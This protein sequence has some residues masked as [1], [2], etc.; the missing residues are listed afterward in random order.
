M[1]HIIR[2]LIIALALMAGIAPAV[3]QS[4][5]PVPPLPDTERRT[6]YTISNSTCSCA[7]GFALYGDGSDYANWIEVWVNG[8]QISQSGNWTISSPS[9]GSLSIA[10]RPITDAVLTFT[11][12]QTG[13]VQIVGARRP[14]RVSQYAE[15]RGVPA[16]NLNQDIS[17]IVATQRETWDKL[18]DVTGRAVLAPPG[19]TLAVL[20]A[21]SSRANSGA[22]FD[23][24]GNLVSCVSIPSTT[25]TAGNGIAITGTNPKTITNNIQA[26]GPITIT[27]TNPLIIGCPTCNTSPASATS[28]IF[29]AS[30]ATAATLDLSSYSVVKTGGYAT[31][32]DGG[33]AT[34]TKVVGAPFKDTYITAGS[35][36]GVGSGYTNGTYLGVRMT[37]GVGQGCMAKVTVAGGVV[38]AVDL[39]GN[40]CNGYAVGNVLTP[41]V[42]DIGGTGSGAAYTVSTI[43]S[44]TASFTDSAGTLWQYVVSEGGVANARQFGMKGDWNGVDASATNDLAGFKSAMAFMST[45]YGS[46]TA[47]V[48]GGTIVFPKGAYYF[49]ASP[50]QFA[51]LQVPNGVAIKGVGV[52]GGTTFKQCTSA[53][54]TEH[55]VSLC[56]PNVQFGQFGCKLDSLALVMTGSSNSLIAAIYSNSGQQFPLVNNVYIQPTTRGCI[57]YE[58]GK[59]G[60]SNAIFENVDCEQSDSAINPAFYGNSSST[61]IVLRNWVFGCAPSSCGASSYAINMANGNFIVE[62]FHIE[63][64]VNGINVATTG[65]S[66][67]S[68]IR[69]GTI[70]SGCVNGITLQNTN[71]NNT[72]LVEN[73]ESSCS[74]ATVL[75]GHASG[76]NVT[77]HILAQRVFNP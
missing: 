35:L 45:A 46:A 61:Q 75:N 30:R 20:S 74:T 28:A 16:R 76:S 9:A 26:G 77:G 66:S 27:G 64:H 11:Q 51:T 3:A 29:V 42:S 34:F 17:D 43:S 72:V 70:V 47:Y 56:D 40:F 55:F 37:G 19:E 54:A 10:A 71:P 44:P 73:I 5:T 22:C 49:C 12:A 18:N 38:T 53:A 62:N 69:N 63:Q 14:R 33:E 48:N 2:R 21:S 57:F 39:S 52:L 15:N 25:F 58:I 23:A 7:V 32:G 8:T 60:A 67:L 13:T 4:P 31:A 36:T 6:S 68:S 65:A 1:T 41:T 24:G 50:S 59:G